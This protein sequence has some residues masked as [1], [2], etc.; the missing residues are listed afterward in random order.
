M[1]SDPWVLT[2]KQESE[3]L[4]ELN[5]EAQKRDYKDWVEAYHEFEP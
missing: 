3:M 4:N 5:A 2:D 1:V